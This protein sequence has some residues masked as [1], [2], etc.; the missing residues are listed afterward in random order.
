MVVR[1]FKLARIGPRADRKFG[2][3]P[4]YMTPEGQEH[5][6]LQ[7]FG[8]RLFAFEH[9]NWEAVELDTSRLRTLRGELLALESRD[10]ASKGR[11]ILGLDVA[12]G[13][14]AV[15]FHPEA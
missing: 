9:R 12:P 4:I 10:G 13:I 6:L 5:P 2:V 7:A 8:D 1:H 3:M 11:A 14:E 15:Q